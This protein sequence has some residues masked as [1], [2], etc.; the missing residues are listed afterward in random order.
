M[1]DYPTPFA[2]DTHRAR[3]RGGA[4]ACAFVVGAAVG[5]GLGVLYAPA[6]GRRVRA[7]LADKARRGRDE[8]SRLAAELRERG[9]AA[10]DHVVSHAARAAAESRE[11][12]AD[13]RAR[14]D[15]AV[16]TLGHEAA[17]MVADVKAALCGAANE[18][19][20]S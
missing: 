1:F 16:G 9:R 19:A 18:K 14:K 17:A 6:A 5:A 11:A 7:D 20:M 13:V 8:A 12:M 4:V 2:A 10:A 3:H 15:R